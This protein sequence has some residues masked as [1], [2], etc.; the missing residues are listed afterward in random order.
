MIEQLIFFGIDPTSPRCDVVL[1]ELQGRCGG[2]PTLLLVVGDGNSYWA[3]VI[4]L[5]RLKLAC[6]LTRRSDFVGKNRG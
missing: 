4:E 3:L 2:D 6:V 1:N 5:G